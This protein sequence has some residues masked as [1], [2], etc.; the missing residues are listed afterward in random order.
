MRVRQPRLPRL[1]ELARVARL[2]ERHHI[3]RNHSAIASTIPPYT[4]TH[5]QYPYMLKQ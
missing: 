1:R 2:R 3:N 5:K 4:P